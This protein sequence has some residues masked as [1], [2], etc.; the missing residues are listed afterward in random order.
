VVGRGGKETRYEGEKTEEVGKLKGV[1]K[2]KV[3]EHQ[4][5]DRDRCLKM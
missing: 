5:P 3:I 2:N 4:P 1:V